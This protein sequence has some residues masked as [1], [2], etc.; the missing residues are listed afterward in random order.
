MLF[1]PDCPGG[2]CLFGPGAVRRWSRR[3]S[4]YHVCGVSTEGHIISCFTQMRTFMCPCMLTCFF[5][6]S[7]RSNSFPFSDSPLY[8]QTPPT[9]SSA[10]YEATPSSESDITGSGTSQP[11]QW[12][13]ENY[14]GA[15]GVSLP[16]CT[17]YYHYILHCQEQ[18]LEPVNAASFGKLISS[19][20]IWCYASFV[21]C[22]VLYLICFNRIKPL[23]KTQ[24]IA[25][26]TS[27]AGQQQ[28]ALSDISAQVQQ[29]QQ[30]LGEKQTPFV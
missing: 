19:S 9:S 27:G 16:R 18:K 4:V 24:G 23:Q 20:V 11:V 15:E 22:A 25:N 17:L 7:S 29:Y 13:L 1:F 2:A 5:F 26:G 12:L 10:F 8:S 21:L 28:V 30:F 14:E 6:S 3:C